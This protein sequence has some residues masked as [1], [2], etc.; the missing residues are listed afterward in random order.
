MGYRRIMQNLSLPIFIN[1]TVRTFTNLK[2][3]QFRPADK[4]CA[5]GNSVSSCFACLCSL[6]SDHYKQQTMENYRQFDHPHILPYKCMK[7]V[8]K[9]IESVL[10][11]TNEQ[12]PLLPPEA[13]ILLSNDITL[14]PILRQWELIYITYIYNKII[15]IIYIYIYYIY[16]YYIYVNK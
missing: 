11:T 16:V 3:V 2:S 12:L 8:C 10:F 7:L 5:Q 14:V 6:L 15:I 13:K 4:R 9:E 1:V